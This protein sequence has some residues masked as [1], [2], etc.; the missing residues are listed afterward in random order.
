VICVVSCWCLLSVVSC[1][2]CQSS[3]VVSVVS[4]VV[5]CC[6]L[7][8]CRLLSVVCC[9]PCVLLYVVCCLLHVVCCLLPV[10]CCLLP[11]AVSIVSRLSCCLLFRPLSDIP[12]EKNTSGFRRKKI[13]LWDERGWFPLKSLFLPFQKKENTFFTFGILEFWRSWHQNFDKIPIIQRNLSYRML[14]FLLS[15]IEQKIQFFRKSSYLSK[16]HSWRECDLIFVKFG[17][18]TCRNSFSDRISHS[19]FGAL[20]CFKTVHKI[21]SEIDTLETHREWHSWSSHRIHSRSSHRMTLLKM[22]SLRLMPNDYRKMCHLRESYILARSRLM[23]CFV[24]RL[25]SVVVCCLWSVVCCLLSVVCCLLFVV[26]RVVCCPLSVVCCLLSVVCCLLSVVCCLLPVVC[27][28]LFVVLSVVLCLLYVVCCLL[29]VVCCLLS[30]VCRVVCCPLSVVCCL[31]FVVL[32]VV[33]C[34]L[35]VVC[36]LLYVFCRL[37]SVFCV[38]CC[39]FLLLFFTLRKLACNCRGE[40]LCVCVGSL[41]DLLKVRRQR[42]RTYSYIHPVPPVCTEQDIC[43]ES[44]I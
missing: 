26:C 27:C 38:V 16:F 11:V 21:C 22:R 5:C 3:V 44:D 42:V 23:F 2:Y 37:L 41:S 40:P 10:A 14:F 24:C 1:L 39:L 43:Y 20:K 9:L 29:S 17:Q 8:V 36:C 7:S 19:V 15:E 25:V 13:L 6:L 28:L 34:L 12:R 32:S 31:L 33:L 30:V 18:F 4:S 35:S